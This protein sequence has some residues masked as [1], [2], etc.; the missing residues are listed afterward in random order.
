MSELLDRDVLEM[1]LREI[2]DMLSCRYDE[3]VRV[4]V[5]EAMLVLEGTSPSTGKRMELIVTLREKEEL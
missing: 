5:P 4:G 2:S 3:N 1:K